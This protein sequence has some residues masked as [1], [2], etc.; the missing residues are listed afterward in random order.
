MTF[1]SVVTAV[2]GGNFQAIA[3]RG[4]RPTE[5]RRRC[6]C[7]SSTFTTTPSISK[8]SSP[9]RCCQSRHCAITSSSL[10]STW[11]SGFTRK[12]CSRSHSS[13]CEWRLKREPLDDAQLIAPHRQR[14]LPRVGRVELADRARGGVAR[15]HERRL[16]RR[17]AA[18]VQRG[19]V[20]QRH[21]HLAAHL[22]QRRHVIDPQRDR[23]DRAQVVR[24]V[25]PHLA[26]AA[27]RPALQH[28]VAVDEADRQPVD[29]RLDH[30]PE[31]RR[32]DALAR[33]VRAH[34]LDPRPQLL[35]GARVRQREHRLQVRDLLQLAH[36]LAA[37]PLGGR[38]GRAQ[39]RMLGL[40]RAQL[41]QQRVVDV[42][43]DLRIVEHVVAMGVVFELRAQLPR[44]R[45]H[46]LGRRH[47]RSGLRIPPRGGLRAIGPRLQRRR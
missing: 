17:R 3:Q 7:R 13:A 15:V 16:A 45:R 4:S 40:D 43:A 26:V 42:V 39:L 6:S 37:D 8:S 25:L 33:E 10:P 22:Q 18:L 20:S 11:M 2:V 47:R 28:A 14:P 46:L 21:V 30:E 35:L 34:P 38:V 44:A 9:R 27:R 24:D 1:S 19:E 5:P 41:V 29:L 23:A 31:P 12:R 36:R 32:G